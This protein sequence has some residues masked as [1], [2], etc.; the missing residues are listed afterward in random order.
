VSKPFTVVLFLKH[1]F[2]TIINK[3]RGVDMPIKDTRIFL[4]PVC[5]WIVTEDAN[6]PGG[7]SPE[8]ICPYCKFEMT[9]T[10]KR[11]I[12]FAIAEYPDGRC[13]WLGVYDA[14]ALIREEYFFIPENELFNEEKYNNRIRGNRDEK[15]TECKTPLE[16]Y[17]WRKEKD[18]YKP[19]PNLGVR[20][21]SHNDPQK[22]VSTVGRGILGGILAG[23]VGA[24]VGAAS[25][26][27]KNMKDKK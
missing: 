27:D 2:A 9:Q 22:K 11:W 10:E 5:G 1:A 6:Q 12:D 7:L 8:H 16:M 17:E 15:R 26:I 23:P 18:Q 25:A 20:N 19:K 24:V 13:K 14:E 21:P 4:C 3:K